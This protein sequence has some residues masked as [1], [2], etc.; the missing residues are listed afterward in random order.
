MNEKTNLVV[1][2]KICEILEKL[3]PKPNYKYSSLI[4]FIKDRP[5]HD[6]RYAIDCSKIAK[7][8]GWQPKENFES[9]LIKTVRWY[10]DNAD[11]VESIL[12]GVYQNWIKQNYESRETSQLKG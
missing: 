4:T 2:N 9:G 11:W 12:T 6:R 5:G 8:L 10:L 7:E 1:V 3:T